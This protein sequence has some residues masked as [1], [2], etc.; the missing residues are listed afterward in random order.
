MIATYGA[1]AVAF[2][3]GAAL[4][5]LYFMLLWFSVRALARRTWT[6]P[7]HVVA[8]FLQSLIRIGVILGGLFAAILSGASAG[9]MVLAMIGFVAARLVITSVMRPQDREGV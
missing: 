9:E 2:V 8:F 7:F 4:G 3:I 6:F 5:V 1:W